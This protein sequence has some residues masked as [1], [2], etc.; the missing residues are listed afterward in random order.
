MVLTRGRGL[1]LGVGRS[2]G[3]WSEFASNLR[4]EGTQLWASG[5]NVHLWSP[6]IC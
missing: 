6:E 4:T 3:V 1:H 2:H 5:D